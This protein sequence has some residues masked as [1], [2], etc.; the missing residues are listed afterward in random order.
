MFVFPK[1]LLPHPPAHLHHLGHFRASGQ[2]HLRKGVWSSVPCE[3]AKVRTP[4][5]GGQVNCKY[6]RNLTHIL[7]NTA[8]RRTSAH[9]SETQTLMLQRLSEH[10]AQQQAPVDRTLHSNP[11]TSCEF[12]L[13]LCSVQHVLKWT[14]SE[15]VV[16]DLFFDVFLFVSFFF[17]RFRS[18][19][20]RTTQTET[21]ENAVC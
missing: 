15:F 10:H 21:R 4:S 1:L 6:M 18:C 9:R 12:K 5:I 14:V 17:I 16:R 3:S 8:L 19:H 2:L 13:T 11:S 20:V 7:T